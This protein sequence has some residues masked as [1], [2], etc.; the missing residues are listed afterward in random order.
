MIFR[1]PRDPNNYISCRKSS[2]EFSSI[3][4][5]NEKN[6][7]GSLVQIKFKEPII[8]EVSKCY[9]SEN[10]ESGNEQSRL[11]SNF[12]IY[13]TGGYWKAAT[14]SKGYIPIRALSA[15]PKFG[16]HLKSL[17]KS[18]IKSASNVS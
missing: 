18:S 8:S 15:L 5:N 7:N 12:V 17:T 13:P 6:L 14:K 10:H 11:F 9:D 2:I 1:L 16:Q 3:N 4:H